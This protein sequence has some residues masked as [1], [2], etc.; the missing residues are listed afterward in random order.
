[1]VRELSKIYSNGVFPTVVQ[2][3]A[4]SHMYKKRPFVV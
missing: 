3:K 1:M 2:E 4:N